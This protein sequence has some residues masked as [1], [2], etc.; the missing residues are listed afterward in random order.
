MYISGKSLRHVRQVSAT[1]PGQS[2]AI[3]G[4]K[5]GVNE[6]EKKKSSSSTKNSEQ[7]SNEKDNKVVAAAND[8]KKDNDKKKKLGVDLDG[9]LDELDASNK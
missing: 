8:M 2:Q 6:E 7:K 1:C 9:L 3:S 4:K 5:R